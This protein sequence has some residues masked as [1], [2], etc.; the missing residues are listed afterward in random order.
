MKVRHSAFVAAILVALAVAAFAEPVS[1]LHPTG[2]VNDFAGVL[3][4]TTISQ[5]NDICRQ[6]DTRAQAQLAIVTI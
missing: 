5:L 4:P 6:L 3:A 1:Q 2:Y